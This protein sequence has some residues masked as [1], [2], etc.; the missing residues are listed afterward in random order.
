MENETNVDEM[1]AM[2]QDSQILANLNILQENMDHPTEYQIKQFKAPFV[3]EYQ[4]AKTF[5][6]SLPQT[7]EELERLSIDSADYQIK[8]YIKELLKK[9]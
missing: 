8:E 6:T 2:D 9:N 3:N 4:E 1:E 7:Q 5:F